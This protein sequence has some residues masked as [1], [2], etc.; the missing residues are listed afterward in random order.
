LVRALQYYQDALQV[1]EDARLGINVRTAILQQ[2]ATVLAKQ[3][4][5][6]EGVERLREVF[7]LL[8]SDGSN[9]RTI[10]DCLIQLADMCSSAGDY[11]AAIEYLKTAIPLAPNEL[12]RAV[13]LASL[14][15]LQGSESGEKSAEALSEARRVIEGLSGETA[16]AGLRSAVYGMLGVHYMRTG[17][18]QGALDAYTVAIE[19]AKSTGDENSEARWR[20]NMAQVYM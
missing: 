19:D 2:M 20:S 17:N 5:P 14:A 11:P 9:D 16:Q 13:L 18:L 6:D 4:R 15:S 12:V 3:G 10:C 8:R 7:S 1:C